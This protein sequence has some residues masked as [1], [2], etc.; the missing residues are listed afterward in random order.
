[1]ATGE[2]RGPQESFATKSKTSERDESRKC[3]DT[4]RRILRMA[5]ATSKT[6]REGCFE[7][8]SDPGATRSTD[9]PVIMLKKWLSENNFIHIFYQTR[10]GPPHSSIWSLL[11]IFP[12]QP[13][14][15]HNPPF[16]QIFESLSSGI[17]KALAVCSHD[18]I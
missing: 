9:E 3:K 1:L 18:I 16:Q 5:V 7:D 6:T 15:V 2:G 12:A 14:W 10:Q 4:A 17:Y 11:S 13:Q 8:G